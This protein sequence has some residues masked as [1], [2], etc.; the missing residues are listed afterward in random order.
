MRTD[1]RDRIACEVLHSSLIEPLR[2]LILFRY[3]VQ[4][5]FL[6][7]SSLISQLVGFRLFAGRLRRGVKYAAVKVE[8]QEE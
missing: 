2:I 1:L 6:A 7:V 4:I 5:R 8:G 3:D